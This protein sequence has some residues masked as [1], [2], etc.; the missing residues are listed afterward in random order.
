M[1]FKVKGLRGDYRNSSKIVPFYPMQTMQVCCSLLQSSLRPILFVKLYEVLFHHLMTLFSEC[2]CNGLLK[3]VPFTSKNNFGY[4][5]TSKQLFWSLLATYAVTGWSRRPRISGWTSVSL[6]THLTVGSDA[7][8]QTGRSLQ[9]TQSNLTWR[10][11]RTSWSLDGMIQS[12]QNTDIQPWLITPNIHQVT[13]IFHWCSQINSHLS[14]L[15]HV[16]WH[17]NVISA[18]SH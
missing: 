1:H 11:R 8:T 18:F 6:L 2:W 14:V 7:S 10:S 5:Y 15:H 9:S 3:C 4:R 17:H 13:Y 16:I 12:E